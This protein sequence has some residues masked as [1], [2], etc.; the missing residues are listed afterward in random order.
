MTLEEAL[1]LAFARAREQDRRTPDDASPRHV[2]AARALLSAYAERLREPPG[3]PALWIFTP[4]VDH[5]LYAQ[6]LVILMEDAERRGRESYAAE[7]ASE[8]DPDECGCR[9]RLHGH[10]RCP[11]C[12]RVEAC[13][14]HADPDPADVLPRPAG[15]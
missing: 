13:A 2:E 3:N 6:A 9:C 14:V 15:R 11:R 12:L 8:L 4:N 10:A 5:E 1:S 7:L